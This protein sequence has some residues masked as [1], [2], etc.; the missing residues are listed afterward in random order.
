M[1]REAVSIAVTLLVYHISVNQDKHTSL[2]SKA[3]VGTEACYR[4]SLTP[5]LG[6]TGRHHQEILCKV[7]EACKAGGKIL[8]FQAV[9]HIPHTQ[10]GGGER[11][12]QSWAGGQ[13]RSRNTRARGSLFPRS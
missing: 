3:R 11:T 7:L 6:P 13:Y 1:R 5:P 4:A 9:L 8:K 2:V 10:N 12:R